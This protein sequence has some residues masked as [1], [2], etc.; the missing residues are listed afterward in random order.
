MHSNLNALVLFLDRSPV[1]SHLSATLR[2]L[3]TIRASNS[4]EIFQ[5]EFDSHQVGIYK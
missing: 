1:F 3:T 2:G 4:Q 5:Q